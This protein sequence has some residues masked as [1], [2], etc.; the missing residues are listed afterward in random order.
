MATRSDGRLV[1]GPVLSDLAGA[2]PAELLWRLAPE[3][4]GRWLLAT[5]PSG[6]VYEVTPDFDAKSFR[7]RLLVRL[8]DSQVFA[9]L[10]LPDGSF[11]AGTSPRGHLAL[12]KD[13]RVAAEVGLPADSIFDFLPD[14]AGA[15]LVATGNP[16][17]IYRVD[18][19]KFAASGVSPGRLDDPLDLAAHGVA[20]FGGIAD[21]NVR[22][23]ARM[24]DGR[25]VAGS[26]PMGNLY[27]FAAS[28]GT[29]T[30]L[31]ENHDAEVTDLLPDAKGD[32]YAAIVYSS[33]DTMPSGKDDAGAADHFAGR[34]VLLRFSPR[35]FPELL[36]ARNDAAFYHLA[37]HGDQILV[38]GGEQGQLS[39]Y[40][41]DAQLALTFGGSP[42]ARLDDIEPVPGSPERFL[43]LQDNAPGI[44]LL[45]FAGTGER[46]AETDEIDLGPPSRLGAV[47]FDRLRH[48]PAT[49]LR[50]DIRASNGADEREGWT[51]WTRLTTNGDGWRGPAMRGR[52]IRLRI[53]I[54]A[55]AGQAQLGRADVYYLPENRRPEIQDFRM[56]S[57]NYALLL[58]PPPSPASA[59]TT[60]GQLV[61]GGGE[62]EADKRR[63]RL[64]AAQIVPSPGTQ[65]VYWSATDPDGDNLVATF[66]I[67]RQGDPHWTDI[68]VNS[69]DSYA[70][71]NTT[72][73]PS[74]VYFARLVVSQAAPRPRAD[75]LSAVYETDDL[76]ID[77]APPA[78]VDATVRR[79]GGRVVVA[80]QGRDPMSLLDSLTVDF[81]NGLHDETEQPLSGIRD[82]RE[83]TF[84]IDEPADR[85]A[86]ATSVEVTLT[87]AAGNTTARRLS[88]P[89]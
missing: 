11:L 47:R 61:S 10:P 8:D 12:V 48:L 60:L 70:Q 85:A 25:V 43:V 32:L 89:P 68:V 55:S 22:R 79:E 36:T 64:M 76:L 18:L 34:S 9:V 88:V 28:G 49:D 7:S 51:P 46:R 63:D 58:G 17:R 45:D 74:G 5:G 31:Q 14:G 67:R 42:A 75:R 84:V 30:I 71:F 65:A 73:L 87:D 62:D 52:Y 13:G 35:A 38:A 40:D 86:G 77:H 66:S 2:P 19:A 3:A 69:A 1:A 56:L 41:L 44:A 78:M 37:R 20:P 21:R 83:E 81:N 50:V 59:V 16:G 6:G 53:G 57:A 24:P 39:G 27:A 23:L 54:P 29:P 80:V 72:D 4:G 82:G 15:A 33:D 26:A